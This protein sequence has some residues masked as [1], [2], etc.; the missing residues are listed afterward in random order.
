MPLYKSTASAEL[1][2]L[3]AF[4]YAVPATRDAVSYMSLSLHVQT[5]SALP[6][7]CLLFH[8]CLPPLNPHPRIY[9]RLLITFPFF[10]FLLHISACLTLVGIVVLHCSLSTHRHSLTYLDNLLSPVVQF[11]HL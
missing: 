7:C 10:F 8:G 6:L 1:S 2:H 3:Y 5:Y 4:A 9:R 11:P